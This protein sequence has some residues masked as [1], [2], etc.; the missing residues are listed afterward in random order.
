[1]SPHHVP[2]LRLTCAGVRAQA[3]QLLRVIEGRVADPAGVALLRLA[4][5]AALGPEFERFS[6][7][8]PIARI[9][10]E[11]ERFRL[12]A[13]MV[14]TAL[15]EAVEVPSAASPVERQPAFPHK[16]ACAVPPLPQ[17]C[18]CSR[19]SAAA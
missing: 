9:A 17:P 1:M 12:E 13:R 2:D 15:V 18:S 14:V 4:I 11:W 7:E 10:G 19:C 6:A 3:T 16:A 8:W 5:G